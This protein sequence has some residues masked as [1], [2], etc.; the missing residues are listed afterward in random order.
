MRAVLVLLLLALGAAGFAPPW[1]LLWLG[2][3]AITAAS[4]L[5]AWRFGPWAFVLPVLAGAWMALDAAAPWTGWAA[6]GGM[7]GAWMGLREEG[8]GPP[9]GERALMLAPLLALS[10]LVPLL[11][12]WNASVSSLVEF[13]RTQDQRTI[14]AAREAG[15]AADQLKQ[16]EGLVR[17]GEAAMARTMP[18]VLPV[19]LFLWTSV[20]VSAG[21]SLASRTATLLGWP[22][23]GASPLREWRLPDAVLAVLIG[24]IALALFGG[25]KFHASAAAL[26]AG[27]LVGFCVQGVAVVESALLSRGVPLALIVLT[28]LFMFVAAWPAFVTTATLLGLSDV[29]LDY[30]RLEPAAAE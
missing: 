2:V 22:A 12:G 19:L 13:V 17:D 28:L 3:P 8:G 6:A 14:V 16:F 5:L 18:Y 15:M 27:T 24:G 10:A 9:A 30:R 29:W 21:R 11:P 4:L 25:P 26:V 7:A 1:A 23:L 20:L